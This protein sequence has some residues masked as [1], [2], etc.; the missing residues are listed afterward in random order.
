MGYVLRGH[1][2]S[3][4]MRYGTM[5]G[6][7]GE[8]PQVYNSVAVLHWRAI[9]VRCDPLFSGERAFRAVC[10]FHDLGP[11]QYGTRQAA[12]SEVN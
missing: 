3:L 10:A 7:P 12:T 6:L 1:G 8:G 9:S 2:H 5:Q 11:V 4:P